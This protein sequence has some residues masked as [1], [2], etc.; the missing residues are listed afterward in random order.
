VA[1]EGERTVFHLAAWC[2]RTNLEM[3][4]TIAALTGAPAVQLV[5]D[6]PGQDAR[7][8]LDDAGTRA[9]LG[10]A[11]QVAL[12]DGLRALIALER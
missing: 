1:F 8:A 6:R 12:D 5:A 3:A 2:H 7:Y 4:E 10:W 9:D 11:P